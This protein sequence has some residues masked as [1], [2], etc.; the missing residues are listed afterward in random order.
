MLDLNI[1]SQ[2]LTI[3]V[4][5]G[6]CLLPH[7]CAVKPKITLTVLFFQNSSFGGFLRWG[8]P[9]PMDFNSKMGLILAPTSPRV[10]ATSCVA[11]STPSRRP[12][13]HLVALAFA[14]RVS[15]CLVCR[16]A[17]RR[18]VRLESSL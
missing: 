10:I 3:T 7:C 17:L 12:S 1:P 18:R 15:T 14:T 4:T 6:L 13:Q 11:T 5:L 16:S 9:K 2:F 8:I